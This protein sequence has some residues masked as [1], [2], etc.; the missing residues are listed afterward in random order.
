MKVFLSEIWT[1]FTS[2]EGENAANCNDCGKLIK[3]TGR[4]TKGMH[5]HLKAI[6]SIQIQK[7]EEP[8][9]GE[10]KTQKKM[11]E[12]AI[13]GKEDTLEAVVS[14]LIAKDGLSF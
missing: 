11:V 8:N 5:V 6:H 2:K 1:F 7:P 9:A 3:T 10:E 4:S 13:T 12:T 14:R